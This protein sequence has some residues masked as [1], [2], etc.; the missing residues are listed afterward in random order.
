M[1]EE[2]SAA[3][4]WSHHQDVDEEWA[5]RRVL[6][7]ALRELSERCVRTDSDASDLL[8]AAEVVRSITDS[9]PQGDTCFQR[10][11]DGRY[12][13][14]PAKF[15]DR[16][17]LTGACNPVAP[18]LKID[19]DGTTSTC[20]ITF[21]DV[22]QGA[23][24]MV[25][26]GWVASVL[27]QVCGHVVVMSHMRGF[28]GKLTVRYRKPTPLHR[29]LLCTGWIANQVGRTITVAFKITHGETMLVEGEALMIQMDI[30][31]AQKVI[32]SAPS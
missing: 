25:H 32:H 19:W 24:G 1:S 31:S 7:D 17:A 6:A 4:Y 9:L 8:A 11:K 15:I 3:Q 14:Q 20:P 23:P 27:D 26:G 30:A 16:T 21:T 22:H 28:T 18:P 10:F 13:A 2:E 5:A 29:P 12:G